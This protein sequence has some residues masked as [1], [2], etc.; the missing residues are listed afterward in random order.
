MKSTH[1]LMMVEDMEA[2][3]DQIS[4]L[5]CDVTTYSTY[6]IVRSRSITTCSIVAGKLRLTCL[7]RTSGLEYVR[8]KLIS[9][10]AFLRFQMHANI[11][12]DANVIMKEDHAY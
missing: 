9:L 6:T 4:F 12:P 10:I 1:E 8:I 2:L 11:S 5:L 7:G 3:N